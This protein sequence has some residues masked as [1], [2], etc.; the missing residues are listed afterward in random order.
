[1]AHQEYVR[2][3][4]GSDTAV[5][6][7]H[8]ITGTP[9]HFEMFFPL[10]PA[11]WSV[12]ALLLEGHGG[13]VLDFGF[14]SMARW[15]A[16]VQARMEELLAAH[17]QVYIV[18]HS[19]GTLFALQ[20]SL[21]YPDR[22]PGLFLLGSPLRVHMPLSTSVMSVRLALGMVDQKNQSARDMQRTF[23]ID[24]SPWLPLYITWAPRFLELLG[25]I[26]QTRKILNQI[27]VPTQ[28][29]Q[30]KNDEL[31]HFS[32]RKDFVGYPTI[33]CYHLMNSGHFGYSPED[34]AFLKEKFA[35]M[36]S[37]EK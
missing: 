19:M 3:V 4:P 12:H 7:L 26:W 21:K 6:M 23:S 20:L 9:D 5:L 33:T 13:S 31:V 24:P 27:T 37:A 30:S 25:E 32:S 34:A 8:G 36:V 17:R 14:S 15:K 18:A 1:M 28:V 29:F 35:E 10:I 22:I 2:M 11:D 16:Q